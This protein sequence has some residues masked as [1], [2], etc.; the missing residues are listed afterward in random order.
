[1][2]TQIAV[3]VA[4][5]ETQSPKLV[6]DGQEVDSPYSSGLDMLRRTFVAAT[7]R[8]IFRTVETVK[9]ADEDR[10]HT[11]YMSPLQSGE[12]SEKIATEESFSSEEESRNVERHA[13]KFFCLTKPNALRP[14]TLGEK[15]F[16]NKPFVLKSEN[17]AEIDVLDNIDFKFVP[18]KTETLPVVGDM[19]CIFPD[20][21][22]KNS[23]A[24]YWFVCSPQ[25]LRAWTLIHFKD[26]DT[27]K[28][29]VSN[30]ETS[31]REEIVRQKVF[32]GNTT[33][34]NSYLS[35]LLTCYQ[36]GLVSSLDELQKRFW[37]LRTEDASRNFVHVYSALVLMMR[38]TE[39]PGPNNI[40]NKL[41][42][43]P[44]F[45][46]WNL[47]FG[48]LQKI[49]EKYDLRIHPDPAIRFIEQPFLLQE[50]PKGTSLYTPPQPIIENSNIQENGGTSWGDF[51]VEE[52]E[53]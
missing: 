3:E 40:P 14:G 21:K 32:S 45:R 46:E 20:E 48:W 26:H 24:K 22:G 16:R 9:R 23:E 35:W 37:H 51:I 50:I 2:S 42:K 33:M 18:K 25:F 44:K 39:C 30:T 13:R 38:Y 6:I 17:Y 31:S 12:I 15:N 11:S 52:N 53:N 1:M 41:D 4:M 27:I 47:P 8:L 7:D 43:S 34:T 29:L 49:F 36:N 28:K 5:F 10:L 19:V